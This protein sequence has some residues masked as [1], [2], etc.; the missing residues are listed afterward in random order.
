VLQDSSRDGDAS[1]ESIF[2]REMDA[3][4]HPT[5]HLSCARSGTTTQQHANRFSTCLAS[6]SSSLQR[7]TSPRCGYRYRHYFSSGP[8][9]TSAL[10]KPGCVCVCVCVSGCVCMYC[11]C[12][13][14]VCVCVC[15]Y[16]CV[17]VCVCVCAHVRVHVCV[18]GCMR[19][20]LCACICM[21]TRVNL[22]VCLC[23]C[24]CT[25]ETGIC[26]TSVPT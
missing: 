6:C 16:V 7:S 12:C 24:V 4:P 22:S 11:V 2:G 8:H 18:C 14:C 26:P 9:T 19:A 23:V 3:H 17:C 10:R 13:A 20:Y 1:D 5:N 21:G 25:S 15:V